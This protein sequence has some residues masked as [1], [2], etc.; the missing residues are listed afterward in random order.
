KSTSAATRPI[1][2]PSAPAR[3]APPPPPPS[4]GEALAAPAV[5][6]LAKELN[7]NLGALRGT[8]PQGRITEDDVRKGAQTPA[9][10]PRPATSTAPPA[11]V[12]VRPAQG[13]EER[14]PIHGLRKRI[15]EKMAKSNVTAAH[16]TYV[17]EVDMS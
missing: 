1:V 11:A 7:V 12:S 13:S 16:F 2:A 9:M 6:R 14:I 8:G 17:E 3:S 4:S 5:R 15:F 10:P